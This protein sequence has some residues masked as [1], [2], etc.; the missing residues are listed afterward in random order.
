MVKLLCEGSTKVRVSY[1]W[2]KKFIDFEFGPQKLASVLTSV[3]IEASVV[4]REYCWS[5]VVTVKVL[6]VQKHPFA[7]KL[8]LCKVTDGL[9]NYS[10]VC[11]AENIS[12]GQ[13]V[14]LAKIGAILPGNV[15]IKR[16]KIRGEDSEGMICSE[17]EL[18]LKKRSNGILT[19]DKDTQ[20]GIGLEKVLGIDDSVLEV[21]VAINRGDCL[22][23]LGIAREIG[24]KIRKAVSYP[25]IKTFN[26]P[27]LDCVKAAPDLCPRYIGMLI[28]DVKVC[29]SPAWITNALEK[30][31][32]RSINNI[33]DIAN[34]VM[35]EL[36]QPLHVF[37]VK[38]LDSKMIFV[39]RSCDDEAI[40]ALNGKKYR[41]D[42]ETIV[43]ADV[44]KPVAIA[45]IMGG[46]YSCVDE[47]TEDIF[48][49]SAIFNADLVRKAS[50][51][52]NLSSDSSYR[53]ER[54]LGWDITELASWRAANLIVEVAGGAI[55]AR[56]DLQ[57]IK[58]E[59]TSVGLRFRRVS[60]ILGYDIKK[61]EV[62]E[63][64]KFLGMS[65]QLKSEIV[66]CTIPSWRNDI[67][68]EVDLI[69]EIARIKGYDFIPT[70]FNHR[71]NG[72]SICQSNNLFLPAIVEDF[73][74]KL[75]GLGFNE[76]LNYSFLEI[77]ELKKFGLDYFYRITNPISKENEV[78]RP[79]LLPALYKNLLLNISYG[80]ERVAFFEYG[81]IF[82]RY[83]E[84]KTFAIIM[85]GKIWEEW[86]K[87]LEQKIVPKYDFYFG[88]GVV[89]NILLS[90]EFGITENL[91]PKNYYH[92]GQ[93]ASVV[94]EEKSVGQF[95]ILNP[96]ITNDIKEDIFYFEINLDLFDNNSV[97]FQ[98]KSI[99]KAYSRLPV[100]KRDISVIAD[101]NLQFSEIEKII[102]IFMRSGNILRKYSLFSAYSDKFKFGENKISYSFRLFYKNDE[103]TL[104]DKE[105][106][107]N[108]M[109][110]LD[111]LYVKLGL[112]LRQ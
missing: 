9:N 10:I 47:K 20:I 86:W 5:N 22:S 38:K 103:K 24:A 44:E 74:T 59:R 36:G 89:R 100:V 88:A 25:A 21:E 84:K 27:N 94:F 91:N 57:N 39:R 85:W 104:T 98:K 67:K 77:D 11:G 66:L 45:G 13:I 35:I 82:A 97:H 26:V 7:N 29:P 78:L 40:V 51:K 63:I 8:F 3:G 96:T 19:L 49:E 83:G 2:L 54:G 80:C 32:I 41:L 112:E 65:L 68:I 1:N 56:Q 64:L 4:S 70:L 61:D 72:I 92:S 111:K 28:S 52:L 106:N 108:M 6:D 105:V 46:K 93:T 99:Y 37:D 42:S 15:K 81:R 69:E 18:G 76:V 16:V 101:K 17:S 33:V 31:G 102:K 50:R 75:N 110:L 90:N 30:N 55:K 107:E 34:Y 79:S 48:L 23:H 43:I 87:W 60:K 14:P 53:F 73:R 12:L 71:K 95:G 58:Y 62:I 109:A